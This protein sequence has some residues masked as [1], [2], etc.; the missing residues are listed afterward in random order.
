M[1]N[2]LAPFSTPFSYIH[3][4]LKNSVQGKSWGGFLLFF[5][6]HTASKWLAW[7]GCP[8]FEGRLVLLQGFIDFCKT[9]HLLVEENAQRRGEVADPRR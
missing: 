5:C 9:S 8:A 4:W 3:N 2:I 1:N 6:A 7:E